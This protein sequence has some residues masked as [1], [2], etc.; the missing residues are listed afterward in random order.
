[1]AAGATAPE[2]G[3]SAGGDPGGP[4]LNNIKGQARTGPLFIA[5]GADDDT[6]I[7]GHLNVGQ[8]YVTCIGHHVGPGDGITLGNLWPRRVI[9]I[10]AV[11]GLLDV[12]RGGDAE[13]VAGI[14]VADRIAHGRRQAMNDRLKHLINAGAGLGRTE[15]RAI[16]IEAEDVFDLEVDEKDPDKFIEVV[17]ALG[18][19][20][21]PGLS[22][23]G[24]WHATGALGTIG[25]TAA[26]VTAAGGTGIAVCCDHGDDDQ[27]RR[28]F[29]QVREEQGRL[30]ILVNNATSL[31]DALTLIRGCNPRP[32]QAVSPVAAEYVIPDVF[33]RKVD[34]R[35]QVEISPTGVPKLSVNQQ[36]AQLLRGNGD[37]AVLRTQL[38][39]ARWLIR[40]L[41]IRNETL[42]KVATSIVKRQTDFL[43]Q[44]ERIHE[45]RPTWAASGSSR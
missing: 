7:V 16:G 11:G 42:L 25:A 8:S 22:F 30:D 5:A 34:N 3:D 31:H 12:D 35:W 43:E 13:V 6:L 26:E 39:E 21:M 38:Q 24:G 15:H 18:R 27:V 28:L 2:D 41:E 10:F 20:C 9:S 36:Y 44:G 32:G 23:L 1:M 19:A 37:H 33:V 45:A 4:G 14:A 29:E 17:A 40:S